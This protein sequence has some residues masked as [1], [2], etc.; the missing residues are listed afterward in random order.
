MTPALLVGSNARWR[1]QIDGILELHGIS[2]EWWWP[3]PSHLGS[4]PKGCELVV[5]ATDNCAHKLSKP[6][7]VRAREAG[8]PLVCGPHRKS[9]MSPLLAKQGFPLTPPPLFGEPT[10]GTTVA[11]ATTPTAMLRDILT[12]TTPLPPPSPEFLEAIAMPVFT[13]APKPAFPH[14]DA[15]DRLSPTARKDYT[16]ILPLVA[17]TPWATA[18][19]ISKVTGIPSNVLFRPIRI[20]REACGI[21]PG[22]GSGANRIT[23]RPRYEAACAFLN[24]PAMTEDIGPTRPPGSAHTRNGGDRSQPGRVVTAPPTPKPAKASSEFDVSH[25]APVEAAPPAPAPVAALPQGEATKDTLEAL[26]L[27]L[28]AMR[29][30]GVEQVTVSDDGK[31]NI[32]RRVIVTGTLTL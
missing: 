7:M 12:D 30:E 2:V 6:A 16:R 28:E 31:V 1:D 17:A 26:R 3:T 25:V 20:A 24:V 23:D 9:A 29:A 15:V 21:T 22:V 5:V 10:L 18:A 13:P 8:I 11:L 27:L 14:P 4:I 32:R 19:E